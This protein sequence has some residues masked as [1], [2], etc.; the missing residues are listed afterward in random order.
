MNQILFHDQ[1][2]ETKEE[3]KKADPTKKKSILHIYTI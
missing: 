1:E 3:R 2:N